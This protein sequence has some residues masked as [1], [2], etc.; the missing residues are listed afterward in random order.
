MADGDTV[1]VSFNDRERLG[2]SVADEE[3]ELEAEKVALPSVALT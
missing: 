3:L 1:V 2:E